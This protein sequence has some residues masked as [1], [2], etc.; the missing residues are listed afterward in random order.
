MKSTTRSQMIHSTT[1]TPDTKPID[2]GLQFLMDVFAEIHA[3]RRSGELM[4]TF[5]PGGVV[6]ATV[7]RETAHLPQNAVITM[8]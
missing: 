8:P 2:G 3:S 6:R 5:G 4:V 7:F 1:L